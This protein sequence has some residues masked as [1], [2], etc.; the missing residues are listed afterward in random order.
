MISIIIPCLNEA[1][2]I[3]DLIQS[4]KSHYSAFEIIVVDGG[5]TDNTVAIAQP[6]ADILIQS[7]AGRANQLNVGA[8]Q[9]T[10]DLL[11]FIHADS[12][13]PKKAIQALV[14]L[15]SPSWGRFDVHLSGHHWSFRMIEFMMNWRSRITGI[16]TGDQA[17]FIST[18]LFSKIGG[19]PPLKL[20]EDIEIS[21]KLKQTTS[22]LCLT[23]QIITSSRRWQEQGIFKTVLKMWWFRLSWFFGVS[24]QTLYRKY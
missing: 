20:M 2:Y 5:S 11:W 7:S 10:G 16:A 13:I 8:Q 18:A 19:F 23:E 12:Q 15:E 1:E 9:A 3:G 24:D 6:L 4:L 14:A 22:P 21:K 17:I